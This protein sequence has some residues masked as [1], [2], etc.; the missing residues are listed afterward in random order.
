MWDYIQTSNSSGVLQHQQW[1]TTKQSI[2]SQRFL[3]NTTFGHGPWMY[4]NIF[5]D[6]IFPIPWQ[7]KLQ[8]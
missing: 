5:M 3:L 6:T 7:S 4:I 2:I 1:V 8:A